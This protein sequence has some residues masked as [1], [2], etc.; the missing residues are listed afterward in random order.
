[1]TSRLYNGHTRF[2]S[3][4]V[5]RHD[6]TLNVSVRQLAENANWLIPEEPRGSEMTKF[7]VFAVSIYPAPIE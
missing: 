4:S 3:R 2:T 5:D 7:L 1:M 6:A